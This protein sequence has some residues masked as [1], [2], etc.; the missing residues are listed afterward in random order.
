MDGQR[1]AIPQ[2]VRGTKAMNDVLAPDLAGLRAFC[3]IW[4]ACK[5]LC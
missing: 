5:S 1:V 3:A 2:H 4:W